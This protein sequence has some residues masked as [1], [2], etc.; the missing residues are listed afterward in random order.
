MKRIL[1]VFVLVLPLPSLACDI[2]VAFSP[3]RGATG[4]VVHTIESARHT[5]R[6]AAYS[7]TSKPIALALVADA[8]RGVDVRVVVDKSQ[9]T[10]R[11]T[12]RDVPRERRY[13]YQG[14]LSL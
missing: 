9:A 2:Q 13:C 4:L 6:V 12:G 7:F 8:R 10:A 3:D 14:G 5:V 1:F 11:Y